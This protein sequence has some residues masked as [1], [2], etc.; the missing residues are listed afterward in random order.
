MFST[1][2]R[3]VV[4]SK[5]HFVLAPNECRMLFATSFLS[6]SCTYTLFHRKVSLVPSVLQEL[7]YEM[8]QG[9]RKWILHFLTPLFFP[10]QT[11]F[12]LYL[13]LL[14]VPLVDQFHDL[15][16]QTNPAL[17][18][19]FSPV[20]IKHKKYHNSCD[21]K[22]KDERLDQWHIIIIFGYPNIIEIRI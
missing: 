20:L 6:H 18:V 2:S 22:Y 15:L 19:K 3:V 17:L 9:R 4:I 12:E 13:L 16:L 5:T 21:G 8:K 1:L 7:F 14:S 11:L 10:C